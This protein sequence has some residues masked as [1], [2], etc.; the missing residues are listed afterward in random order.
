VA[1]YK[2]VFK[3]I[4]EY[5]ATFP[6]SV[7]GILEEMREAIRESAPKAQEVI[8]Y[9]IPAF[10]LNGNLVYFAAFKNHIGFYPTSSGVEKFKEELSNYEVS[11]G[12]IR[13]PIDKPVP[14]DLVKKIVRYRV[15]ENLGKRE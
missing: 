15:K 14:F 4:D 2:R 5:I 13:F 7:Q 3:T 6:K 10:K 1:S 9:Q 8:S 12:T 11:K